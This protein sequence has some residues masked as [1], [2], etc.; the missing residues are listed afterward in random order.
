M[1][2][3]RGFTL[4]ELMIVVAI[5]GI[6]ASI[7]Y[8]NY[9][10]YVVRSEDAL[11]QAAV[12][13]ISVSLERYYIDNNS[14][15]SADTAMVYPKKAPLDGSSPTHNL[16]VTPEHNGAGYTITATRIDDTSVVYS[17]DETG[18]KKT[19]STIGWEH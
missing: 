13:E 6:L 18:L 10:D 3:L 8:P 17:L 1:N 5:I 2:K 16:A 12:V 11:A 9:R 4:I 7:A 19:G 14:Y 15:A